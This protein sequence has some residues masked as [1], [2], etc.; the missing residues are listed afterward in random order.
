MN[1]IRI[2][3]NH[4]LDPDPPGDRTDIKNPP[5]KPAKNTKNTKNNNPQVVFF[6]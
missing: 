1:Q 3:I 2:E 6:K 4:G 5:K